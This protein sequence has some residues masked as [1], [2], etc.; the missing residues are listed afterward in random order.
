MLGLLCESLPL[1]SRNF[2]DCSD[3]HELVVPP[4]WYISAGRGTG[5]PY[6]FVAVSVSQLTF[7]KEPH[8]PSDLAS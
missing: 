8:Q 5:N 3:P 4:A 1:T 6:L 7:E 2:R